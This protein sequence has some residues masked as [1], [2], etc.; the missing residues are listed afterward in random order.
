MNRNEIAQSAVA[1]L[2]MARFSVTT[3]LDSNTCFDIIARNQTGT[4]L[5]K[6]YEN[7]DSVRKEQADELFK[8]GQVLNASCTILG[9]KTKVFGMQDGTVYF[10]YGI[11][12]ITLETFE[13][14]LRNESPNSRYF[15]GKYIVDMDSNALRRKRDEMKLSLQELAQKVGV[16]SETLYRFEHG[17]ST[18]EDTA[19]RIGHEL[20]GDFTK[21][22]EVFGHGTERKKIDEVPDERLL[23]KVRELGVKMALFE[24]APFN[25]F[26]EVERGLLISTGKGNADIPKKAGE[27]SKTS[28]VIGSDSLI[29]TKEYKRKSVGGILVL[30]ESDLET[31]SKVKDLRK[32]IE[33]REKDEE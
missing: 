10:R 29:I 22:F 26:G 6:V 13:K 9:A 12:A 19:K 18:T 14:A 8:L 24:H 4:L 15:K 23:E 17:A 32:L 11:P 1:A 25:A 28:K 3:F 21:K 2:R 27:L 33:E 30:E 16:A 5:I 7:I 31:I 20:K